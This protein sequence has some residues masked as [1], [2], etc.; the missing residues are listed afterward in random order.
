MHFLVI[1]KFRDGLTELSRAEE[2]HEAILGHLLFVAQKVAK[3]GV[4]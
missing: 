1:P 3:Q 2:R 4:C